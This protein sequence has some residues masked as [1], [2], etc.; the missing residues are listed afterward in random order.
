MPLHILAL[1]V[2]KCVKR[3]AVD[4]EDD[5]FLVT[6]DF[7]SLQITPEDVD[8]PEYATLIEKVDAATDLRLTERAVKEGSSSCMPQCV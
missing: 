3:E 1:H 2:Q 4:P 5:K 8:D 6:G 7:D